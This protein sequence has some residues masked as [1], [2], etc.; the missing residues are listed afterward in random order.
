MRIATIQTCVLAGVLA[1]SACAY[2]NPE[3]VAALNALVGKSEQELV[4]AFGVPN[5]SIDT[6]GH[7]YLAYS[8]SRIE[9]IPGSPGFG[10]WGGPYYGYWGGWGG[11]GGFPPEVVTRDCDTT[12]DL[13]NGVV[14]SWSQRG[15][16]C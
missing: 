9:T 5:R 4:K 1:M 12:F 15:N 7:R 13:Q 2:P 3:K 8:R 10:P 16:A 6:G 11:W 14:L